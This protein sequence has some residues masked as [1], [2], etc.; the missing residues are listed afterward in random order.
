[1]LRA[2]SASVDS[3]SIAPALSAWRKDLFAWWE[4]LTTES[5]ISS[6]SSGISSCSGVDGVMRPERL[7]AHARPNLRI[8]MT[9]GH[10]HGGGKQIFT[11]YRGMLSSRSYSVAVV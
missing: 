6:I 8:E 7:G 5:R 10:G 1:M 2:I 3:Q 9:A 11:R 4:D